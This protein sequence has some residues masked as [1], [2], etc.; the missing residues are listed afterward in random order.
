MA[1]QGFT[2]TLSW[3]NDFTEVDN[4]PEGFS[5]RSA[6]TKANVTVDPK[7]IVKRDAGKTEYYLDPATLSVIVK[8]D[9]PNSWVVKDLKSDKLLKHEQLHYNIAALAGR[10]LERKLLA[11]RNT[12]GKQLLKD[13][14]DLGK[15]VQGE[16]DKINKEYDEGLQGTDHGKKDAEQTKWEV[17]IT[18]L[19]NKSD[20]ELKGI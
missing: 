14:E 10:D 15:A 8:T 2:Y 1:I 12:D 4:A 7:L 18:S 6:R 17:H 9:K 16:I 11:L 3:A 13:K 19:M 5:D 20:A